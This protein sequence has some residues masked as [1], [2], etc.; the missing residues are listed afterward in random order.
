MSYVVGVE[1]THVTF[2]GYPSWCGSVAGCVRL[3]A[4]F[5]PTP[6]LP[7]QVQVQRVPNRDGPTF[8]DEGYITFHP[9]IRGVGTW[10]P[11]QCRGQ[12]LTFDLTMGA[13]YVVPPGVVRPPPKMVLTAIPDS[14]VVVITTATA[15]H[16][17]MRFSGAFWRYFPGV[18][19]DTVHV[20]DGFLDARNSP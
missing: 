2:S 1:T 18:N 19:A 13:T 5:P 4:G 7:P 14:M 10:L 9:N 20:T 12:C 11:V 6:G 16:V 15:D 8:G 17:T 3:F